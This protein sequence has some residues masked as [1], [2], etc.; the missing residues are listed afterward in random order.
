MCVRFVD[1][2]RWRP[3]TNYNRAALNLFKGIESL[4]YLADSVVPSHPTESRF[5]FLR[6][7]SKSLS[8]RVRCFSCVNIVVSFVIR[9]A[10]K[11]GRRLWWGY[12]HRLNSWSTIRRATKKAIKY[13]SKKM[14][15]KPKEV[16]YKRELD[17]NMGRLLLLYER[18]MVD[19]ERRE[20]GGR[21]LLVTVLV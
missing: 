1:D 20:V 19:W 10:I 6:F 17:R 7:D 3:T 2:K 8:M 16:C 13:Q 9:S 18:Q 21:R 15:L 12:G 11:I 4:L 14:S 5:Y